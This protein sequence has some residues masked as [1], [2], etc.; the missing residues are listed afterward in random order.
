MDA[1]LVELTSEFVEAKLLRPYRDK[2]FRRDKS[3]F[4]KTR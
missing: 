4:R 3:P 2:R 1:L